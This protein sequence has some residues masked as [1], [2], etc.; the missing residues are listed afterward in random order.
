[1]ADQDAMVTLKLTMPEA[2]ALN[3]AGNRAGGDR[4][5]ALE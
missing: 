1:M 4:G 5:A 3:A 2:L